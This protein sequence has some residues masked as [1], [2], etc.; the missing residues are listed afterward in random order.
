VPQGS[1][2]GPL[3]FLVYINDIT[4][5]SEFL[6][7]ILFAD[8]TNLFYSAKTVVELESVLNDELKLLS[9]W[10]KANKLSLNTEKTSYII[11]NKNV[12]SCANSTHFSLL[13]DSASIK[14]VDYCKFLGVYL[15]QNLNWKKHIQEITSKITKTIGI[16]SKLKHKLP[17][18]ILYSLH[19]T[20]VLPYINYCNIGLVWAA[21]YSTN[22][23][24]VLLLQKRV[25][26]VISQSGRIEHTSPLFKSLK[27]LKVSE[28]N[29]LQTSLFMFQ[30]SKNLIPSQ[31]VS[32]FS[33]NSDIHD[34]FTRTY[35][36]YHF[37]S[38]KTNIRKFSIK[39]HGPYVY[40]TAC[41]Y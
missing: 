35:R 39:F 34:H 9:V 27:I 16:I 3:L 1:I 15:D 18:R 11:F 8:D 41:F 14:R 10:F 22:L 33:L 23:K 7:F 21:N 19:N 30:L 17:T 32:Y 2:L 20:M 36:H 12:S 24:R 6:K 26:R 37:L 38:T 31:F 5:T 13:I 40:N 28:I 4:N 29:T 25:V